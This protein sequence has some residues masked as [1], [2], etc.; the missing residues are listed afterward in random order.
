MTKGRTARAVRPSD[1]SLLG[2]LFRLL[3][4]WPTTASQVGD[5]RTQLPAP[6]LRRTPRGVAIPGSRVT[7]V[8]RDR[9]QRMNKIKRV[10]TALALAGAALTMTGTA[11]AANQP[12]IAWDMARDDTDKPVKTAQVKGLQAIVNYSRG[13]ISYTTFNSEFFS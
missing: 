6:S 5:S 4:G 10:F 11:H 2:R 9:W 8:G 3:P 1:E 13:R 12:G 7:H